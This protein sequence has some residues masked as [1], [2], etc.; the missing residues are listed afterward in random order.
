MGNTFIGTYFSYAPLIWMNSP[1]D[2]KSDL[3]YT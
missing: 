1:L 2:F 3:W